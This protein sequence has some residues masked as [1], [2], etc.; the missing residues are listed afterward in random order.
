M[1]SDQGLLISST[2]GLDGTRMSQLPPVERNSHLDE[3]DNIHLASLL[4]GS[5]KGL[6]G[7]ETA[8]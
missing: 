1:P 3:S 7:R 8:S 5:T 4:P 6:N 2:D